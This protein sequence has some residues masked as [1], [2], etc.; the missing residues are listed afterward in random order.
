LSESVVIVG[1]GIGGLCAAL[2]LASRGRQV[3]VLE[4][5]PPPPAEGPETAFDAWRRRGV[6]HL[7]QSHGF[8]ARLRSLIRAEHPALYAA[9]MESGAR[10][11]P[12]AEGL[13]PAVKA[14]YR[15]EPSDE[16]LTVI[17]SRRTTI[18]WVLRRYV[19]GLPN[20]RIRPEVFVTDLITERDG[21]GVLTARGFA[22][23]RGEVRADLVIDAAGHTSPMMEWLASAG[24]AVPEEIEPCAIVYYTRF[25]RLLEGQDEPPR[26][27]GG[28][29]GD[30][31][32][33]KFGVFPADNRTFSITL[34]VPEVEEILRAAVV[35]PE[36]FDAICASFPGVAPWTDPA[37]AEPVSRVHGM[38][39]LESRWREMAPDGAPLIANFFCVGDSLVRTNPLFGRGCSF[40]AVE[41][42]LLRDVLDATPDPAERARRYSAAVRADLRQFYED[43]AAQDRAAAR[44]ALRGLDPAHK[45]GLRAKVLRSFVEDG[46]NIAIRRDVG[47][48]RAAL[49]A[50]HMLEPPRDWLRRP[51]AIGAVLTTW[52]RGKRANA[53]F[54]PPKPGPARDEMFT[55][56]GLDPLADLQ[57]VQ[58]A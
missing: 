39:A 49:R 48:L 26:G 32:F 11:L 43:M 44:R 38:G 6:G 16:E 50:F 22:T 55:A 33:I 47:L 4:R 14:D 27:R 56:L 20:V 42:H 37:R 12:F 21:A 1:A 52:A 3:T 54:Y 36:I 29:T 7:R 15:P 53:A 58:A 31:G 13:P 17:V 41:A 51:A 8:L 28:G 30:L 9:L 34:A 57:R 18:E 5:D 10:E 2:A 24:A 46:L 23:D 45:P 35:R 25:Y 19:A 40:A